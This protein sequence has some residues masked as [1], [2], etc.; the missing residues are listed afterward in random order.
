MEHIYPEHVRA[1]IEEHISAESFR[2]RLHELSVLVSVWYGSLHNKLRYNL[3]VAA[4][5]DPEKL[6][7]NVVVIPAGGKV[8]IKSELLPNNDSAY[9]RL[10]RMNIC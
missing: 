2:E 10:F 4:Q 9:T 3:I 8:Q 1:K 6:Q 7:S 5:D